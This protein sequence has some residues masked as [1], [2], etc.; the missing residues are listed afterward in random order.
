MHPVPPHTQPSLFDVAPLVC[1][2]T[3]AATH[4][5]K[6]EKLV[7]DWVEVDSVL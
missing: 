3:G 5:Q 1:V 4:R 7:H 6:S 2:Q